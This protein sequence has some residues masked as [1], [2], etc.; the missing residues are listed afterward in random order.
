MPVKAAPSQA[1]SSA[2]A[3]IEK[4]SGQI[5]IIDD[6][7]PIRRVVRLALAREGMEVL[8]ARDGS[9]G[10]ATYRANADGV[11]AVLLDLKMPRLGGAAAYRQ[12][13]ELNA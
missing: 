13:R 10:V 8:T 2:N 6:E 11:L 4:P 1:A 7:A 3:P 5:L 9:D 12:I